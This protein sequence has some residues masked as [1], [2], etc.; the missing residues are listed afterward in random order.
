MDSLREAL[1]HHYIGAIVIAMLAYD[2]LANL[3]GAVTSPI[4]FLITNV[5]AGKSTL[6]TVP[7]PSM[8]WEDLLPL[9]IRALLYLLASYALARWIYAFKF[10]V[11][12]ELESV[13]EE[14]E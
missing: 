1:R 10:Q 9:V 13:V 2:G 6:G 12:P 5:G 8:N 14:S 11:E 4:Y 7:R 3:F